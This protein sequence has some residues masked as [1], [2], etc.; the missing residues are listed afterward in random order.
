MTTFGEHVVLDPL[1]PPVW[2]AVAA[3]VLVVAAVAASW[4]W[5]GGLAPRRRR[6]LLL[7]RLLVV[8]ALVMLA[9]RP[10]VRWEGRRPV[11]AEV[12]VLLDAS[13][14]MGIR[15]AGPEAAPVTR[16]E[17]VREAFADAGAALA[18]VVPRATV[19]TVARGTTAARAA[20]ASAN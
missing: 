17:A 13:R 18:A 19:R 15:D 20:P 11:P 2:V 4:R 14:S 16:A 9:L 1:L 10:Q 12:V 8:A 6:V 5:A 3:G 7:L